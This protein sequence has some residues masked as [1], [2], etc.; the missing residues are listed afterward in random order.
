MLSSVIGQAHC[1][2]ARYW[3][4]SIPIEVY[5][6][7]AGRALRG[8]SGAKAAPNEGRAAIFKPAGANRLKEVER[9]KGIEPS[10]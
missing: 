3:Q 5:R 4:D 8:R 9:V 7:A 10:S 2:T 6:E 1:D